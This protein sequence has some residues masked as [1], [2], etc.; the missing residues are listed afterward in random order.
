MSKSLKTRWPA[1]ALAALL[2][3]PA[4]A[5]AQ[6]R[7]N[8]VGDVM[9]DDGPGKVIAD[10][11]DPFAPMATLLADAD[12]TIGNLETPVATTG[13]AMDSKIFTFRAHP[14]VL[15]VL[16]R[17]LHA[18]AL[19]N[20]HSGDYGKTAFSETLALLK[21]HG[22]PYFGGGAN[23]REAHTP[24]WLENPACA[25]PCSATTNSS[26]VIRGR[27]PAAGHCLERTPR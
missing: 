10:G 21:Q 8:L 27:R 7:L 6:L 17:H 24:L 26:R 12:Y 19:A 9:L 3:G 2:A 23:L 13:R 4:Q 16:K 22:I 25:W 5:E 18:V 20:N 1:P 15:L 11:R 14:R